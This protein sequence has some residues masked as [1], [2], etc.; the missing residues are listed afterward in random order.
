MKVTKQQLRQIIKEVINEADPLS[1]GRTVKQTAQRTQ[2]PS[3]AV[4]GDPLAGGRTVKQP[5]EAPPAV[6]PEKE[7]LKVVAQNLQALLAKIQQ[8]L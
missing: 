1:G 8:V 6:S 2:A 7:T 4:S 5:T 3:P